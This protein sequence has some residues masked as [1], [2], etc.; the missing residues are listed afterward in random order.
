MTETKWIPIWSGVT[1]LDQTLVLVADG[2]GPNPR[3]AVWDRDRGNAAPLWQGAAADFE[4][5]VVHGETVISGWGGSSLLAACRAVSDYVADVWHPSDHLDA[6]G[7]TMSEDGMAARFGPWEFARE[8]SAVRVLDHGGQRH[9]EVPRA[10]LARLARDR[11]V[12]P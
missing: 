8:G 4:A 5:V 6:S 11:R 3:L 1:R 9:V 2:P 10:V 12:D 7:W